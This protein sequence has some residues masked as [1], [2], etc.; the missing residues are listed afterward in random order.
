MIQRALVRV[1]EGGDKAETAKYG[2]ENVQVQ[3]YAIETVEKWADTI[4]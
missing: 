4:R 2:F 1:F 3:Y